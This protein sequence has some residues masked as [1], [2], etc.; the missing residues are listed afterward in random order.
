MP[1]IEVKMFAGRTREQKARLVKKLTEGTMEALGVEAE[2][3]RVIIHD[4]PKENW[5]VAG[6]IVADAEKSEK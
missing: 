2:V 4:I 3:V 5:S 1:V 6:K